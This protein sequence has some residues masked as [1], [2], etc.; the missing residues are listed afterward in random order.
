MPKKLKV[1]LS[2]D[3]LDDRQ[4][5]VFP[6]IGLSLIEGRADVESSFLREYSPE[7]TPNQLDDADVLLS[8]KPKV[9][10][11]SLTG[12]ERLCAIGRY[13][14]GY[15]NVDLGACTKCDI[16]VYITRNAFRARRREL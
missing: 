3:F 7:Y 12:I 8:L 2:A 13:G 4:K 6:D 5:P 16:A 11:A 15:D 1:V 14:V 10:P 9:T